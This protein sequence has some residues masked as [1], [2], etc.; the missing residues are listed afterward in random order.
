MTIRVETNSEQP[1]APD[2]RA[3]SLTEKVAMSSRNSLTYLFG[4]RARGDY[5][6]DRSDIDILMVTTEKPR[7]E[8]RLRADR[9]A[10]GN[11]PAI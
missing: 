3:V 5:E 11:A 7:H 9:E 8:E 6:E 4:S 2:P 10:S 1:T